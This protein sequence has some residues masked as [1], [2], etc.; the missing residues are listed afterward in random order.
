MRPELPVN[1]T[2]ALSAVSGF[3][4]A[5][6]IS[7]AGTAHNGVDY[8]LPAGPFTINAGQKTLAIPLTILQ[9]ATANKTIVVTLTSPTN[10]TQARRPT[11]SPFK[12]RLVPPKV[13]FEKTTASGPEGQ[14]ASLTVQLSGPAGQPV[15]LNYAVT[16]GTASNGQD[17]SLPAG[18][19]TFKP[20]PDD[21]NH[22]ALDW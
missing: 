11:R 12:K 5:F 22:S 16:G 8:T 6:N 4:A 15:L 10:A 13:A 19:L 14:V 18:T 20:G 3:A 17:F 7:V 2:V 9:G 21:P 1:L